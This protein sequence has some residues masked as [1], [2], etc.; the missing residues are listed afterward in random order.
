MT[1]M[2]ATPQ[3]EQASAPASPRL[4]EI[5]KHMAALT[6]TQVLSWMNQSIMVSYNAA[7]HLLH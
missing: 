3:N 1:T 2:T 7:R 4:A 5:C 6:D